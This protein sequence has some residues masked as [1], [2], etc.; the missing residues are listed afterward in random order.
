MDL[1]PGDNTAFITAIYHNLFS[2]EPDSGGLGFWVG[3]L[4]ARQI[5]RARAAISLMAGAQSTDIDII[6]KKT[7][8]AANFTRG[9]TTG[10]DTLAAALAARQ[11]LANVVLATDVA[12]YQT[13]VDTTLAALVAQAASN[14]YPQVAAIIKA[15]CTVCHSQ[16]PTFPGFSSP[17]R[18]VTYDTSEEIHASAQSINQVAGTS[19]FMPFNNVTNM[20]SDERSVIRTWISL[21]AP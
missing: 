9:V 2:R 10:Y 12:A 5:T 6:T 3:V 21:G 17:P 4:D 1:Y 13:T 18:G 19:S 16:R 14:N 7:Q 8:V 15:R 11:M 20:T